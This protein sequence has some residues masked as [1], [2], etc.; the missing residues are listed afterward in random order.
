MTRIIVWATPPLFGPKKLAQ[1]SRP[2][3]PG[4]APGWWVV[5]GVWWVVGFSRPLTTA[6]CRRAALCG[7]FG[8]VWPSRCL[9]RS[10]GMLPSP[11]RT[12]RRPASARRQ[13]ARS[14]KAQTAWTRA[15]ARLFPLQPRLFPPARS[16]VVE[17][18]GRR[19]RRRR[20][21]VATSPPAAVVVRPRLSTAYA[22]LHCSACSPPLR[23][24][25]RLH[26]ATPPAAHAAGA[27]H[28]TSWNTSLTRWR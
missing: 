17:L 19:R 26:S 14:L 25:R 2:F 9:A 5:G 28:E 10:Q 3:G 1:R 23:D 11:A 27:T 7:S 22:A 24:S 12:R 16:A 18:A 8:A 13:L 21:R 15:G 4:Q 20:R 6:L